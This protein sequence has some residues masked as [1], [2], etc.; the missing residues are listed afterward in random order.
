MAE[1]KETM[2]AA[3]VRPV[4]ADSEPDSLPTAADPP[5]PPPEAGHEDEAAHA[6]RR[7]KQ[8]LIP[9]FDPESFARELESISV[10][11]P[12]ITP[13]YDP[14][15][16]AR[17]VDDHVEGAGGG[18]DTPRTLTAMTPALGAGIGDDSTAGESTGTIGR[19]MYGS[20]LSSD[21]PEA[22]VLA[23]RVLAREPEH[24][25]ARLVVEG[26]RERLG[27]LSDVPRL[28][29]SSVVRLKRDRHELSEL[30]EVRSDVASQIVLG[31]VDGVADVAMLAILA[32]IPRPEALDRLHAL[33]ELG[34]LE[35]VNA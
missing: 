34:V 33:L 32:G 1:G 12:T 6:A 22:L 25:L 13:A 14:L 15:S 8:T 18:R 31:H 10:D 9:A 20:Y 26:C 35:V 17:I 29:H 16:Y 4:A 28:S 21:Y 24:A 11:R 19:A 3:P 30:A 23:E 7:E 27:P 2:P 5:R